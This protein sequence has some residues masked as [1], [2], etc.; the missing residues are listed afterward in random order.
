VLMPALLDAQLLWVWVSTLWLLPRPGQEDDLVDVD[1]RSPRRSVALRSRWLQLAKEAARAGEQDVAAHAHS[2]V[3][4]LERR[5][6][7]TDLLPS[8][9]A[10]R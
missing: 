3:A 7:I 8:Y 10:F 5:F 2:V 6:A 4:G 1:A 9:P